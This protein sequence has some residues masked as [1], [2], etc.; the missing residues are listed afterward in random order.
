PHAYVSGSWYTGNPHQASTWNYITVHARGNIQFLGED[1][2]ID[3][4][5]NLSLYFE[6]GDKNSSTI[7]DN[8]P[9]EYV[10][11][12]VKAIIA[13]EIEVTEL[14]NVFKL[15]QN[16]DE[17]SYDNIISALKEQDSDARKIAMWM[18]LRKPGIK[19]RVEN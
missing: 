14:D 8:L 5:K 4:L 18:E 17:K 12:L 1:K 11:K 13:F 2:L 9:K 16:R 19:F 10:D 15:S 6:G 7:Y 3:L